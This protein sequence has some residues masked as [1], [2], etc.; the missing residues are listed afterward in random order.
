MLQILTE[1]A[2]RRREPGPHQCFV[3]LNLMVSAE[4]RTYISLI[5][6]RRSSEFIVELPRVEHLGKSQYR[7]EHRRPPKLKDIGQSARAKWS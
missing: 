3:K 5:R 7:R 2:L 6:I 1:P 4:L